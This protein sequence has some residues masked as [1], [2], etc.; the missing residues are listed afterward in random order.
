MLAAV[1][2]LTIWWFSTGVVLVLVRAPLR[3]YAWSMG[4]MSVLMVT[5]LY[6][7]AS[8]AGDTGSPA[9]A[10]CSF[11]CGLLVWAWQELSYLTGFLTGPR[12]VPCPPT[13]PLGRRFRLA[14]ATS[15]YHE[16]AVIG[17]GLSLVAL[18]W[19]QPNKVALWTYLVLW[20]MRWSAK[21]NLFLGVR[22]F[23]EEW[24]PDHLKFLVSYLERRPVNLLFPLSVTV[25]SF[26]AGILL[27]H[28]LGHDDPF[29][30]TAGMLIFS[31]LALAILEHW[32]LLLPLR[33][34]ALWDWL[35]TPAKPGASRQRPAHPRL[36]AVPGLES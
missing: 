28:S 19:G 1:F 4:A 36:A 23:N 25:A 6:G 12:K 18:T 13:T 29:V 22:N 7:V 20:V 10:Y 11:M 27:A 30:H 34:S 35:S 32:L 8:V 2:A 26:V 5:A 15:V 21:L 14:L 24:F 17:A 33:S 3:S 16:I 31:M 9:A